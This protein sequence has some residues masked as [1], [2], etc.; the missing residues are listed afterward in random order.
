MSISDF[1][2]YTWSGILDNGD[3]FSIQQ[4]A[5]NLSIAKKQNETF[6][7][8]IESVRSEYKKFNAQ[9]DEVQRHIDDLD[10]IIR[11]QEQ[12]RKKVIYDLW[13]QEADKQRIEN[14]KYYNSLHK[15]V[16]W[17][18]SKGQFI[19]TP[20]SPIPCPYKNQK[21]L[22]MYPDEDE[23]REKTVEENQKRALLEVRQQIKDDI[24]KIKEQICGQLFFSLRAQNIFNYSLDTKIWDTDENKRIRDLLEEEPVIKK[25]Q[26]TSVFGSSCL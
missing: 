12:A 5:L 17:D 19:T 18:A 7:E 15:T 22:G 10:K 24:E 14:M 2:S 1:N 11:E 16:H 3:K 8:S 9:K 4:F 25:L 6:F 13:L 26:P 20:P 21:T 23:K